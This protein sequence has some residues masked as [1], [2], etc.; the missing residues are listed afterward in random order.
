MI[1]NTKNN[2]YK[3]VNK[4]SLL[5]KFD[6]EDNIQFTLFELEIILVNS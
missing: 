1:S 3:T 6:K 5:K 4:N 2:D